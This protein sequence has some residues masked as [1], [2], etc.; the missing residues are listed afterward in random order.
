[1]SGETSGV[2]AVDAAGNEGAAIGSDFLGFALRYHSKE[3]IIANIVVILVVATPLILGILRYI[4]KQKQS[5]VEENKNIL[6]YSVLMEKV[7]KLKK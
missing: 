2:V 4:N 5:Q 3:P 7:K 1:M 6:H